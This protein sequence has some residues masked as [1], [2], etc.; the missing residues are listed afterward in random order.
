VYITEK[1]ED[2]VL[3][4]GMTITSFPAS[5]TQ[6]SDLHGFLVGIYDEFRRQ[7]L[8]ESSILLYLQRRKEH[9]EVEGDDYD[10]AADDSPEDHLFRNG[11]LPG[12]FTFN[13]LMDDIREN[14]VRRGHQVWLTDVCEGNNIWNNWRIVLEII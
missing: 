10:D 4:S 6:L 7:K 9:G 2:G 3:E 8:Y 13:I 14:R 5:P 11:P 1:H 12:D